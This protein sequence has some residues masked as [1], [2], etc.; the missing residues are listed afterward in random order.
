MSRIRVLVEGQTEKTFIEMLLRPLFDAQGVYFHAVMFRPRGG[1]PNY[2]EAKD[3]V[4]RSLKE[5]SQLICTTMVDFYALP[6]DWPGREQAGSYRTSE[7]KA[8]SIE[9]ALCRDIVDSMGANFDPSRF[10]PYVQMHEFEALLF[11]DTVGLASALGNMSL[12]ESFQAIRDD[13]L[14]PEDI[15]DHYDTCPSRRIEKI[16]QGFRKTINGVSAAE[17]IGLHRMRQECA[18]FDRWLRKLES[19][20]QQG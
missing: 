6:A 10:I 13:F 18:H 4:I 3:R 7:E 2:N 11:S 20:I 1:V 5:D 14:S 15:N 19:L 12:A 8:T 17:K 9:T 16:Y